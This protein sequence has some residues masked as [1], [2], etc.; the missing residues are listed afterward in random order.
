M[1]V[2]LDTLLVVTAS[3]Q[4]SLQVL[5]C[6]SH[7]PE[8]VIVWWWS[9]SLFSLCL[10]PDLLQDIAPLPSIIENPELII[11]TVPNHHVTG[12]AFKKGKWTFGIALATPERWDEADIIDPTGWYVVL[13]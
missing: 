1:K 11:S 5:Y 2:H 13:Q 8:E 6:I 7:S 3:S 4:C 12:T 10:R 9:Q